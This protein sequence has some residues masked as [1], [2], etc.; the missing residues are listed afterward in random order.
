M[1]EVGLQTLIQSQELYEIRFT[2]SKI[3]SL[4]KSSKTYTNN[5][6]MAAPVH[7]S[8][9]RSRQKERILNHAIKNITYH[10]Q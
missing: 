10:R 9:L 2:Y 7:R 6:Q 3:Y 1:L 8:N 5:R 4:P